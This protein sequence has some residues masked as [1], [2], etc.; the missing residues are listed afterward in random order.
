[1][2]EKFR[3]SLESLEMVLSR[4]EDFDLTIQFK[5]TSP[6]LPDFFMSKYRD[7][8]RL[9]KVQNRIRLDFN[10]MP[11]ENNEFIT[12]PQTILFNCSNISGSQLDQHNKIVLVNHQNQTFCT[13]FSKITL[14]EKKSLLKDIFFKMAEKKLDFIVNS[15][16]LEQVKAKKDVYKNM[17]R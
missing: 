9:V 10:L 13:P 1:M 4:M 6:I 15:V 12:L 17:D 5:V 14:A 7:T 16:K 11:A 8:L 3:D 2:F